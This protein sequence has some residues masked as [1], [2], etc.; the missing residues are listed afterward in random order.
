MASANNPI[1]K[2]LE[3]L[4][5]QWDEFM[6]DE[7][8]RALRWVVRADEFRGVEAWLEAEGDEQAGELPVI[9]LR[10]EQAFEDPLAY[11]EALRQELCKGIEF[12]RA[13]GELGDFYMPQPRGQAI[14][15]LLELAA[16]L[17]AYE[18]ELPTVAALVL[19]PSEVRDA[20]AW[21]AWLRAAARACP[22]SVRL[23]VFDW[24]GAESLADLVAS[25]P[26][27]VHTEQ[28]DLD[29][30]G[31]ALEVSAQAGRL[32]QPD[33]QF[34]HAYAQML[35]AIG[36]GD[37]VAAQQHAVP[38]MEVAGQQGWG[39]LQLAVAFG[40]GSGFLQAKDPQ[41]AIELYYQ[42]EQRALMGQQ[43]G[44]AWALPLQLKARLAMGAAGV[45][46]QAWP[47]ATV[48]YLKTVPV[49]QACEDP[50]SELDCLRMASYCRANQGETVEAWTLGLAA[51][52]LGE[53][54]D[55]DTRANSTMAYVGVGLERLAPQLGVEWAP[56]EQRLIAALGPDWRPRD[57]ASGVVQMPGREARAP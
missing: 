34:R 25:E 45:M 12:A 49:A 36:K 17:A 39:H 8:A 30:S 41:R 56:V 13:D 21:Q 54:M 42:A 2:R 52:E 47:Q 14:V 20:Q 43:S 38:A 1:M 29:L 9:F 57:A 46:A 22:E 3:L 50:L 51:L 4:Y 10:S 37:M 28:A 26:E 33:G 44:A 40:L 55:A 15:D 31:A 5:E 7:A 16:A 23:V 24:A 27:L 35:D 6:D 18:D 19:T 32:D 11:A 53:G 48:L